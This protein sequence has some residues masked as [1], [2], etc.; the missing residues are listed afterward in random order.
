MYRVFATRAGQTF[1]TLKM[2]G[3]VSNVC[4]FLKHL[5]AKL[6]DFFSEIHSDN[7][8]LNDRQVPFSEKTYIKYLKMSPAI[9]FAHVQIGIV[10]LVQG[11][12]TES[13]KSCL[14][15]KKKKKKK[16]RKIYQVYAFALI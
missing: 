4:S 3:K 13:Y 1:S 16:M 10:R 8:P 7:Q 15:R 2:A 5:P 12:Q 14:S 9:E 11:K 6:P